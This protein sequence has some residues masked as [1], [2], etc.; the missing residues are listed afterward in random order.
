M[1]RLRQN[2]RRQRLCKYSS[3]TLAVSGSYWNATDIDSCGVSHAAIA[4]VL[5]YRP[6]LMGN[7]Y[8]TP[9]LSEIRY[10]RILILFLIGYPVAISF[11]VFGM[12]VAR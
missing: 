9:H 4:G 7:F 12:I 10:Q 11:T 8:R 2:A 5:I 1:Y 6:D 3:A